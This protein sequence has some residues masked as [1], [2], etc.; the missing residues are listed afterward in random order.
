M[1][2]IMKMKT[3]EEFKPDPYL[4]T[5][6]NCALWVLY[7]MPFVHPHSTLV[8]TINSFG[9]A[10]EAIYISIF[11]FYSNWATSKKMILW[12]LAEL[13][14]FVAVVLTTLLGVH[15]TAK[16]TVVVG[17]FCVAMNIIMYT[18][19]LTVMRQ[20]IKT[21]SVKYMPF[22]LSV[23]SLANGVVWMIYALISAI[24]PWIAVPN[25]LGAISGVVQLILYGVYYKTTDWDDEKEYPKE[26]VELPPPKTLEDI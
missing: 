23:A 12:L 22:W 14:L 2:R 24:D 7:G 17:S 11:F 19:P 15:G 9:L 20:V 8:I 10:I 4:A 5:T 21:K 6:L 3:V 25:G 1:W 26:L 13:L 16:R 18:A